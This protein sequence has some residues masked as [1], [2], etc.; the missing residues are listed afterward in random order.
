MNKAQLLKTA[1]NHNFYITRKQH[2][3]IIR[4]IDEDII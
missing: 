3:D 1:I 4:E 2:A